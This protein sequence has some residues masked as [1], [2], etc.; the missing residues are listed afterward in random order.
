MSDNTVKITFWAK[1]KN[2]VSAKFARMAGVMNAGAKGLSGMFGKLAGTA[3]ELSGR[4]GK[5]ASGVRGVYDAFVA[6]GPI[7]AVLA[8]L[9]AGITVLSDAIKKAYDQLNRF[10][11]LRADAMTASLQ[12]LKSHLFDIGDAALKKATTEAERA[13]K[14]FEALANAYLKV[15]KAKD[16][17]AKAGDDAA[18]AGMRRDKAIAMN[19][20]GDRDASAV[21]G[22][23]WDVKIAQAQLDA[24]K[25]EQE[26]AAQR[27]R[28]EEYQNRIRLDAAAANEEAAKIALAQA[29]EDEAFT[30]D[31]TNLEE[32]HKHALQNLATAEKTMADA[33]NAR[34]AAQA[35]LDASGE[36]VKQAELAMAAKLADATAGVENAIRTRRELLE[37]QKKAQEAARKREEEEAKKEAEAEERSRQ[38]R[39]YARLQREAQERL[40]HAQTA[41]NDAQRQADAS[42]RQA[43]TAW[44][45]YRSADAWKAQLQEERDDAKA[46]RRFERDFER[47]QKRQDWRTAQLGDRDELVRRVALAREQAQEDKDR[48]RAI[49]ADLA[50][51]AASLDTIRAAIENGVEL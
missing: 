42:Q 31:A 41:V 50:R 29:K 12:R 22:A 10:V 44:G 14:A 16:A 45:W 21:A 48:L 20:A 49:R 38:R 11:Q 43:D 19:A 37:A 8:G 24:A 7:G 18:I 13:A 32:E 2:E 27:A 28:D 1:L 15:A 33:V 40:S 9:N 46:Q 51:A 47:L 25:R 36:A 6:L 3:S 35:N 4:M 39:E 23:D 30:R 5:V 17:T 26:A 34:I